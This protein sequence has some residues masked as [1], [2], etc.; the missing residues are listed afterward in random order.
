MRRAAAV[1]LLMC[2]VAAL[3]AQSK[4]AAGGNAS[5]TTDEA[6]LQKLNASLVDSL[7]TGNFAKAGS[8]WDADGIYYTPDGDKFAGPSQIG[9]ALG[10]GL[11]GVT[12]MSILNTSVHWVTDDIAAVQGSWQLSISDGDGNSGLFMAVIRRVAADWKFVEV[13]PWVPAQ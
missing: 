8:L 1:F 11:Q 2:S 3:S 9:A 6:A 5:H 10:D 4:P 12:K 13:R 7:S